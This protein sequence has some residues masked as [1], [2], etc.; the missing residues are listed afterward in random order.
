MSKFSWKILGLAAL[1]AAG[2]QF[3]SLGGASALTVPVPTAPVASEVGQWNGQLE[4]VRIR[5][6]H[7]RGRHSYY[8]HRH[9]RHRRRGYTHYY[10]GWWYASP[11]WVIRPHRVPNYGGSR[12]VNWCLSRYRSYRP[13]TNMYL[14]FDGRHHRCRSPFRR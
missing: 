8:R 13:S 1:A 9:Y 5:R 2:A 12:H 3:A 11:W 10:G 14:G 7:Y 4:Q 6:P